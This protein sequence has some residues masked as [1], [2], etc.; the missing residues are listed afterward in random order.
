MVFCSMTYSPTDK[1]IFKLEDHQYR[2]STNK[3]HPSI[4]KRKQTIYITPISFL[5]HEQT[6]ILTFRSSSVLITCVHAK[7]YIKTEQT[8]GQCKEIVWENNELWL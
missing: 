5:S 3:N 7:M 2:E 8:I 6:E 1:V 4:L